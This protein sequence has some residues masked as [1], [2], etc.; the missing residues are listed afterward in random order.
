MH[1]KLD[2]ATIVNPSDFIDYIRA[3]DARRIEII[4]YQSVR[5]YL[6]F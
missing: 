1:Q 3:V 6:V 2:E 5:N 4:Q